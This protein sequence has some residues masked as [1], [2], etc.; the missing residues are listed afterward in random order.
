MTISLLQSVGILRGLLTQ[1]RDGLTSRAATEALQELRKIPAFQEMESLGQLAEPPLLVHLLFHDDHFGAVAARLGFPSGSM[2]EVFGAETRANRLLPEPP[3]RMR[4]PTGILE[5]S[6]IMFENA[7]SETLANW[8]SAKVRRIAPRGRGPVQS[9]SLQRTIA[10]SGFRMIVESFASINEHVEG[11]EE[12]Y[13]SFR[14]KI[15]DWEGQR[16]NRE[17]VAPLV[18]HPILKAVGIKEAD[19]EYSYHGVI[20]GTHYPWQAWW[21]HKNLGILFTSDLFHRRNPGA[22]E[23]FFRS[24]QETSLDLLGLLLS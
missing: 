12:Y 13:G 19:W 16:V 24:A 9:W 21:T 22:V 10:L 15:V 6:R 23:T 2:R 3:P 7:V 5:Q 14:L 1:A 8:K 20:P 18:R 11:V 4:L 17:R